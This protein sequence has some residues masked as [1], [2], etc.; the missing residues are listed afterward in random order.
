MIGVGNELRHDDAAGLEAVRLAR[1]LSGGAPAIAFRRYEGETLGLLEAW[2]RAAAVVLADAVHGDGPVGAIHR[3]DASSLP[4]PA[5]LEGSSST[6]AVGVA[7]AI[8]LAREL[9]RLPR[10]VVVYG[11]TG[12]CFDAGPGL[13]AEVRRA[14]D[15][16]ARRMLDEARRLAASPG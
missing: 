1:A 16:L 2:D 8:E 14:L 13:S 12:G 4:L 10:R 5:R 15:P 7:E 11:V 9:G 3:F 6:H